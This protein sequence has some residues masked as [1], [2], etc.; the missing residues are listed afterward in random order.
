MAKPFLYA[1]QLAVLQMIGCLQSMP[2]NEMMGGFSSSNNPGTRYAMQF[3]C[4]HWFYISKVKLF[5]V[6][7]HHGFAAEYKRI[8]FG[9]HKLPSRFQNTGLNPSAHLKKLPVSVCRI[10]VLESTLGI[11]ISH[12]RNFNR[13]INAIQYR[14]VALCWNN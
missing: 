1:T 11:Q 5:Q 2:A 10:R 3:V 4:A 13:C 14:N 9:L 6:K 7:R 12:Q 8:N